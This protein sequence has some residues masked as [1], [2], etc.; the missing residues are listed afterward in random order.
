MCVSWSMDGKYFAAP[1]GTGATHGLQGRA[2]SIG[3]PIAVG[4]ACPRPLH[5]TTHLL[6]ARART[7]IILRRLGALAHEGLVV[8]KCLFVCRCS[9]SSVSTLMC[10]GAGPPHRKGQ[11]AYR[12]DEQRSNSRTTR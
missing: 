9:F 5:L 3:F 10:H 6:H 2:D 1:P 11:G 4:G 8:R 7:G 12:T